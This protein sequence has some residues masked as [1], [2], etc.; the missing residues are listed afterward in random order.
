[1]LSVEGNMLTA[2]A[3]DAL[4]SD[5]SDRL[6]RQVL[7]APV[8]LTHDAYE[9]EVIRLR[10]PSL[11]PS[12][13][14][15]LALALALREFSLAPIVP[16]SRTLALLLVDREAPVEPA[17][18][19]DIAAFADVVAGA[20]A[21]VVV[22]ARQEEL[23]S[24]LR[25]LIA[26]T[27]A[28]MRELL[29]AP[30]MLPSHDGH[31]PSFPLT[32]LLAQGGAIALEE[33]LSDSEARIASLLVEGRSNREIADQLIV[34]PETVKAHVARILRKLGAANRV[35]AVA[36]IIRLSAADP[37]AARRIA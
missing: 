13:P 28:L 22:R 15:T 36:T 7:A 23:T 29:E 27:Q 37:A 1:V 26:S 19:D 6:R 35:E 9:A 2:E 20:L 14:S 16:E 31:R 5:A 25:H 11:S 8:I 33:L 4:P 10:R 3:T 12:R 30:V 21:H 34:S 32:G 24:D 17:A 18:N